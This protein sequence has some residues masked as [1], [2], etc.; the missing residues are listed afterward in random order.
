MVVPV[1]VSLV[2]STGD[3][4]ED[5]PFSRKDYL[6][7]LE[8]KAPAQTA[9]AAVPGGDSAEQEWK[10]SRDQ[11]ETLHPCWAVRRITDTVL[12]QEKDQVTMQMKK[13][14]RNKL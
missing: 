3:V 11:S 13:S 10:Y 5:Q 7:N 14:R 4:A 12:Q 6:L 9:V 8:F 1:I 2:K